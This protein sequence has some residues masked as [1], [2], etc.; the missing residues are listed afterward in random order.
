MKDA[1]GHGSN[2]RSGSQF[3]TGSGRSVIPS[4]PFVHGGEYPARNTASNEAAA[5]ALMSAKSSAVPI[6]PAMVA[7]RFNGTQA[8]YTTAENA[9]LLKT[10]RSSLPQFGKRNAR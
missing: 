10:P 6:H 8:D 5:Q 7:G 4:K 9:A 2:G 1:A 3:V